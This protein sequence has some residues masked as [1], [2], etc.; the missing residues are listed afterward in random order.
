MSL[1]RE[2]I[3]RVPGSQWV[4]ERLGSFYIRYIGE[5]YT[6]GHYYSPLPDLRYVRQRRESLFA[7]DVEVEDGVDLRCEAQ[8]SLLRE[9]AAA[10]QGL[11]LHQTATEG[12]RYYSRNRFFTAGCARVTAAML[13]HWRP[14]RVMEIGSGFSSA[15]MLD[16]DERWLARETSFTFV[17]PYPQRLLKRLTPEDR[18]R[19]TI[20]T[21][22]V[23]DVPVSL[24]DSL[25]AGDVLFVDSSHVA[26]VGSDVNHILFRVLPRLQ[27]GVIIHFHDV[28]WPFEY[29][30]AWIIDKKLAWNECYMLRAFLQYN[31]RFEILLFNRYLACARGPLVKGIW[32]A[33]QEDPGGGLWIRRCLTAG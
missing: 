14:R 33:F 1:V 17:D 8:V 12:F 7:T 13:R 16:V 21:Q 29:P 22:P 19:H 28:F 27:P 32:P 31:S 11:K 5:A 25:E 24:F 26:K 20:I 3:K 9:L 15:L 23:Q 2:A 4:F 10:A 6:R 18:R 30:M